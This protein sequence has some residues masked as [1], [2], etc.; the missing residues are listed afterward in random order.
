MV[1]LLLVLWLFWLI[2]SAALGSNDEPA[3]AAASPSPSFGLAM[4]PTPDGEPSPQATGSAGPSASSPG[5]TPTPTPSATGACDDSGIAVQVAT[6]SAA[7]T[8]GAGLALTMTVRSTGTGPC[9][10]DVGAGANE[11]R[12]TSGSALVWSSDFC[13]PSKA[14]DVQ[15]LAPGAAWSTSVAWPGTIT[16]KACPTDQPMAQPGNYRVTARNGAVESEPVTFVVK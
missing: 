11:L 8:V 6:A 15:V 13:S 4:S 10:R 7:T 16:R 5:A 1:V 2:V 12:I 3:D 9:S 14:A